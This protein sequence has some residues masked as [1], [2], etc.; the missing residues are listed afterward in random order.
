[1]N[2]P[3]EARPASLGRRLLCMV[4]EALIVAALLLA[5]TLLAELWLP[6]QAEGVTGAARVGLQLWLLAVVGGYFVLCWS[7]FGQTLAMK[8]WRIRVAG[9]D[10]R[11]PAVWRAAFRLAVALVTLPVSIVW[12]LVDRDGCFLHDRVAGTRVWQHTG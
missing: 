11:P 10:G 4:Y 3:S 6:V 1:M 5:G 12:A 7:R 8:T 9:E 2:P